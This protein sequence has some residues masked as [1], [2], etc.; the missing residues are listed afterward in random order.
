MKIDLRKTSLQLLAVCMLIIGT[1]VGCNCNK[2]TKIVDVSDIEVDMQL[3]RFEQ[4]LLAIDTNDINTGLTELSEKYPDFL[5]LYCRDLMGFGDIERDYTGTQQNLSLFLKDPSVR[6]LF[7]SVALA[8][9]SFDP[10]S[11]QLEEA[12]KHY[13]YYFPNAAV[14]QVVTFVSYFGWGAITYD[15]TILGI[16]LDM[17]L[18]DQFGY[19]TT[20][21]AFVQKSLSEEYMV[22]QSMRVLTALQ[23]DFKIEGETLLAGMLTNGKQQYLLDLLMP[24]AAEYLKIDWTIEDI[25]WCKANEPEIWKF[26]IEKE[27]LYGSNFQENKK[28][29]TAGPT[30]AGM[31]PDSPGNIG[32]WLGWQIVNKYMESHPEV[33]MDA[34]M[35]MDA[36]ELLAQSKYKPKR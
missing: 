23:Y 10:Q 28:Y 20:I 25:N 11:E 3:T 6:R 13:K 12:L 14:P 9:P 24:R 15:T 31:P 1:T 35:A 18:G 29:L 30:T 21:P 19:P 32:T 33:T 8:Y 27:L 4:D 17:Y 36:Q 34:L 5:P 26:F 16:G 22:A 7:D 2:N